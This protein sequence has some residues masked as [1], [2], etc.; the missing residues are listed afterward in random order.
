M[1]VRNI[2]VPN[3]YCRVDRMDD[4][5]V[6]SDEARSDKERDKE[7]KDPTSPIKKARRIID[8]KMDNAYTS[9]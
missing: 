7:T 8:R 5:R 1:R 3:G 6:A 9:Y 2:W 4:E